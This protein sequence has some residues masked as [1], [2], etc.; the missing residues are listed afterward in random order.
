[1]LQVSGGLLE[2]VLLLHL[3]HLELLDNFAQLGEVVCVHLNV[4]AHVVPV[5]AQ[6]LVR[7]GGNP[8]LEPFLFG[9]VA[10]TH[11]GEE[12]ISIFGINGA[13][14]VLCFLKVCIQYSNVDNNFQLLSDVFKLF[15]VLISLVLRSFP[16]LFALPD[17]LSHRYRFS[18]PIGQS[19]NVT[20]AVSLL[21]VQLL[22]VLTFK[23]DKFLLGQLKPVFLV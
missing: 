3:E 4:I 17:L 10:G 13:T 19:L 21:L 23:L 12:E 20:L 18:L 11:H 5:T 14:Q 9:G 16:Q 22:Y 6:E 8:V 1:M 7:F 2:L 15:P